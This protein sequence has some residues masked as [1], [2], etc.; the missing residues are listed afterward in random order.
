[1]FVS[2][3][4]SGAVYKETIMIDKINT[5][6][7]YSDL[8][9]LWPMWGDPA[10]E[11][12]RYDDHVVRLI[13]QYA[14]R[15][16]ASL[17]DIGCGGGKNVFNLKKHFQVTGLDLSPAMLELAATLNPACEFIQGD[18]RCFSLNRTF[19]AILM[20]DAISHMACRADLSA[21]FQT[22]F[23]HLDPGGVMVTTADVTTETF[24]QNQT[25][26]APA[27]NKA[28]PDNIDVV[29]IENV[30]DPDPA[31]ENFEST[32]L[33]LIREDGK[34][35]METDRFSLGLFPLDIWRQTLSEVGFEVHEGK[36]VD[37]ENE[38]AIFACVKPS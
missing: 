1:M 5:F 22:A 12:A 10:G 36:Y 14:Q 30:Y 18:M 28:K 27:N 2:P 29:F 4:V 37:D 38:Y 7:L 31:D 19:D 25:T 33:Y 3:G 13:K 8:S 35:R 15:P 32:I 24:H 34:L 20:D 11:Y 17:L 9:W 21:A 26:A 23:R 6:R 16:V